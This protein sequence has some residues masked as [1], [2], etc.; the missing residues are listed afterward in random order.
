MTPFAAAT[1]YQQAL[2]DAKS[3]LARSLAAQGLRQGAIATILS[4]AADIN[5]LLERYQQEV[6]IAYAAHQEALFTN[7]ATVET[8]LH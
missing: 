5:A 3:S 1:P 4:H 2:L 8:P 7:A 6:R